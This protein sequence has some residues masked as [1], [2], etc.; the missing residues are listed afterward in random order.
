VPPSSRVWLLIGI[1]LPAVPMG[2]WIGW[3]LNQRLDQLQLYRACYGLLTVTALK[4]LWDGI[5]GYL[6]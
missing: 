4:L 2:V 6:R 5:G 1:C 3:K